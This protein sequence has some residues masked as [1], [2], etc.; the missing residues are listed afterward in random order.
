[1]PAIRSKA[2]GKRARLRIK[3]NLMGS[4]EE[5]LE[6]IRKNTQDTYPYPDLASLEASALSYGD[7][8]AAFSSSLES[9]GGR[10]VTADSADDI[11]RIVRNEYPDAVR[12]VSAVPGI[13]MPGAESPEDYASPEDL[14]GTD[15]AIVEGRLG[16][17]ENG[18]VWIDSCGRHRALLFIAEAL[19]I[20]LDKDNIVDNMHQA[21]RSAELSGHRDFGTFISGPSKT[22]DIEQALVFGAHG[23]RSVTVILV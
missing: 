3:D 15:V 1:M 7:R 17:A 22:A 2:S 20:L 23:A 14:D 12:I 10:A 18:A 4:R 13:L 8:A 9:A 5:I 21:Y 16:V 19:V 11:V 6:R